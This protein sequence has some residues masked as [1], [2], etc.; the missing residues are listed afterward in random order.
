M[1]RAL[2]S[3]LLCFF[4]RP[5]AGEDVQSMV[6]LFDNS[7]SMDQPLSKGRHQKLAVAKEA[8]INVLKTLP[9]DRG[10]LVGIVTFDGWA[11]ELGPVDHAKLEGTVRD[12]RPSSAGT[13]LYQHMALSAT[14]L[15]RLKKRNLRYGGGEY[16]LLVVTDGEATHDDELL[17]QDRQLPDGKVRRGV[18]KN[19]INAGVIVDAI[20]VDMQDAHPLA[21]QINGAYTC[22]DDLKS[23]S[24]ALDKSFLKSKQKR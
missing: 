2:I 19:I 18:L 21:T 10:I 15:I 11:Y 23:L 17:N 4:L 8:L 22:G 6:I 16:K 12:I 7:G 13:P 14:E 20:G 5:V 1:K 24:E 9:E 3:I